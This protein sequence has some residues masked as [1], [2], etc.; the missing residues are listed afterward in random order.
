MDGKPWNP[1]VAPAL[2]SGAQSL[3]GREDLRERWEA[4]LNNDLEGLA[5]E[6]ER[7]QPIG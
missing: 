2:F 6:V 1:Q 5:E 7:F 3:V 4:H